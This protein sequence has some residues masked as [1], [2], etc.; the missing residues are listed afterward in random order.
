MTAPDITVRVNQLLLPAD[1]EP[2]ELHE[3]AQELDFSGVRTEVVVD[4]TSEPRD[5]VVVPTLLVIRFLSKHAVDMALGVGEGAFWDG[6]K[7]AW[8]RLGRGKDP[9]AHRAR[10]CVQYKDGPTVEV[11]VEN[12]HQLRRVLKDLVA[13][14]PQRDD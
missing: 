14:S 13:N 2:A 10:A 12:T 7:S 9:A 11:D 3:I 5:F 8:H 4:M 6:V 1:F